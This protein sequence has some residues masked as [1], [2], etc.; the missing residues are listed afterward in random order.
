HD[1]LP[2]RYG[3][4]RGSERRLRQGFPP[5]S[6]A[7]LCRRP[8]ASQGRPRRDRLHRGPVSGPPRVATR[9]APP[10]ARRLASTSLALLCIG[11]PVWLAFVRIDAPPGADELERVRHVLLPDQDRPNRVLQWYYGLYLDPAMVAAWEGSAAAIVAGA[12]RAGL[13][14]LLV[15]SS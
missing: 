1:D 3:G 2:R 13:V 6:G 8:R 12:R 4:L 5:R 15:V 14:A 10:L 7:R 11:L 9:G